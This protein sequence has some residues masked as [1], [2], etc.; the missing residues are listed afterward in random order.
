[1]MLFL[2]LWGGGAYPGCQEVEARADLHIEEI[3][4]RQNPDRIE[5]R[6][7]GKP[8]CKIVEIGPKEYLI[9][10]KNVTVSNHTQVK[11]ERA[12]FITHIGVDQPSSRVV[13]II[14]N[15]RHKIPSLH[16]KW[17]ASRKT[18]MIDFSTFRPDRFPRQTAAVSRS[19]KR[20]RHKEKSPQY[21]KPGKAA[22]SLAKATDATVSP[23]PEGFKFSGTL[24]D[25][26]LEV[27]ED[28]C[29]ND[30]TLLEGVQYHH[31]GQWRS[32]V[33]KF[34][35]Y[36]RQNSSNTC[37]EKAYYMKA[38]SFYHNTVDSND[39][40]LRSINC[41]EDA[42]NR[43]PQSDYV[44]YAYAAMGKLYHDLKNPVQARAYF[45]LV[46]K[47]YPDCHG[48]PEVMF[49]LARI[50]LQANQ[51]SR[52]I[53]LYRKIL[54]EFAWSQ[55][56][57]PT[58]LELAQVMYQAKDYPEVLKIMTPL[59]ESNPHIMY[60]SPD[61]LVR[62][63]NAYYYTGAAEKARSAFSKALNCFP[64]IS[65]R[66]RIL[67][68]IAD[69][70]IEQRQPQ[71][72]RKIY[73][74]IVENYPETDGYV[75]GLVRL[76][77]F[78]DQE[79]KKTSLYRKVVEQFPSH[80][81]SRLAMIRLAG[82]YNKQ[83]D[84]SK[85]IPL[86][87]NILSDPSNLFKDESLQLMQDAYLAV[88]TKML[89]QGDYPNILMQYEKKKD[90]LDQLQN[91][92]IF[93]MIGKAYNNA[94]FYPQAYELL[95]KA[96]KQEKDSRQ[97]PDVM[98]HLGVAM[99][100]TQRYKAALHMFENL[101]RRY[102]DTSYM[103]NACH[104]GGLIYMQQKVYQKA[105]ERFQ[106]ARSHASKTA[107][108]TRILMDEALARQAAGQFKTAAASL[109][110]A[111]N[112]LSAEAGDHSGLIADTYRRLGEVYMS[113]RNYL[114]A[115]DAFSMS[116]KFDQNHEKLPEIVFAI[117]DAYTRAEQPD[118]ALQYY[119]QVIETEAPLWAKL[120]RERV[121]E[122]DLNQELKKQSK[123]LS[124]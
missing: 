8:P 52:A 62:M 107:E 20:I 42:V 74:H 46:L 75:T 98:Y 85:S 64:A 88:F 22:L 91:S 43:F 56:V 117:A 2:F 50:D 76:A 67:S 47:E 93:A 94:D 61:W 84:F 101:I 58:C 38:Y 54:D 28:V 18:L 115:A 72:A 109:V 44:P 116:T 100:E 60:E 17:D 69:S 103:K 55:M 26:W 24:N 80:S 59:A 13:T 124:L 121:R 106:A 96:Y 92:D 57:T 87:E 21:K 65:S 35:D 102:P 3:E 12:P 118:R 30:I 79:D 86:L 14:V 41:F 71:K 66:D 105:I 73:E 114:K 51:P 81:L 36:I 39:E 108:K 34:S 7:N 31:A 32:A 110:K 120:A 10:L 123:A 70:F 33:D 82:L 68:R 111:I 19:Q 27:N 78:S 25:F 119:N 113:D 45:N 90:M 112:S 104:R 6:L 95:K 4:L 29:L 40:R 83:G 63:G 5:I 16:A 49:D 23:Q 48:K 77:Q 99:H 37:L 15:T 89:Q 53:S 11:G 1:M 122:M 97:R 9:A